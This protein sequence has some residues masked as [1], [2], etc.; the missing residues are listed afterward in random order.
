MDIAIMIE[1][2]QGLTWRRWQRLC[3]AVE[4]LGFA[5]IYRSDHFTDPEPPAQDSL[6][7]WVS[8]TWAA[9]HTRRIDFGPLVAP[10]S[11]RDPIMMARMAAQIDDL[12]GGRLE[13]GL[14][15]GWNVRE[16][17][18]FGYPLLE[19]PERFAR[20][21]EALDVTARLL[22]GDGPQHYAGQYYKLRDAQLLPRPARRAGPPLVVGGNGPRRTLPLAARY[23]DQWNGVYLTAARFAALN[24]TL[25][26]LLDAA[27]RPRTAVKRTLMTGLTFGQSPG[28]VRERLPAGQSVDALRER[29]VV[30]G[31]PDELGPQ[32]AT[33]RAAGVQRLMLQWLALDDLAGLE[34][35]ARAV[36]Q[37]A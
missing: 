14:G 25:D 23:A 18:M 16:H 11:F 32:L 34:Q 24:A 1:G 36:I 6:E 4:Q 15:A 9:S 20:F 29:G 35:L 21:T 12:S 8:L 13:L 31:T 19:T 5:G 10:V 2:Q 28:A 37:P 26:G 33:L 30:V 7:L 27:A 17:T 22:K 3:A